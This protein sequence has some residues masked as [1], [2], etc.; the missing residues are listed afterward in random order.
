MEFYFPNNLD[1]SLKKFTLSKLG[2]SG[3]ETHI[4]F[5][6][7]GYEYIIFGKDPLGERSSYGVAVKH[8]SRLIAVNKCTRGRPAIFQEAYRILQRGPFAEIR[9]LR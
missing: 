3:S 4:T 9:G 5:E 7:D 2:A 1:N 6:N 8:G